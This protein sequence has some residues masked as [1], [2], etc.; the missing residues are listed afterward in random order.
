MGALHPGH[1]A[2]VERSRRECDKTIATIFVN[3]TQFA[4]HEDLSRYPRTVDDDLRGP[5]AIA[6]GFGVSPKL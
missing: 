4:P 2:L 6:D 5:R 1:L 3:P